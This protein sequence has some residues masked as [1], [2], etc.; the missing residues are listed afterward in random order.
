MTSIDDLE[1]FINK[2][3]PSIDAFQRPIENAIKTGDGYA[4]DGWGP[5]I[6]E[7]EAPVARWYMYV[8]QPNRPE[9]MD[10]LDLSLYLDILSEDPSSDRF[11]PLLEI[12]NMEG[13]ISDE[14]RLSKEPLRLDDDA[15][16]KKVWDSG[17]DL[18][19]D[20]RAF[21]EEYSPKP[22]KRIWRVRGTMPGNVPIHPSIHTRKE[23]AKSEISERLLGVLER[24]TRL[25]WDLQAKNQ[26]TG[27]PGASTHLAMARRSLQEEK[28]L[29]ALSRYHAFL[30]TLT[31]PI[32]DLV[33]RTAGTLDVETV[34][35]FPYQDPDE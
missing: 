15:G 22:T 11:M 13:S 7:D 21:V 34:G 33:N 30:G 27:A 3:K 19:E 16:W 5:E 23:V 12:M 31:E 20:I 26:Y 32:L 14:V 35:G 29:Y 18:A 25:L 8:W 6:I 4:Y 1:R 17:E 9:E 24:A 10:Y 2:W 28:P